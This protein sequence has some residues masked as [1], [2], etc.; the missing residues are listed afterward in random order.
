MCRTPREGSVWKGGVSTNPIYSSAHPVSKKERIQV[1]FQQ[2]SARINDDFSAGEQVNCAR[3]CQQ[4]WA[5]RT[6]SCV[7]GK[8][9]LSYRS[10]DEHPFSCWKLKLCFCFLNEQLGT[11]W[12]NGLCTVKTVWGRWCTGSWEAVKP[13]VHLH[14][15]CLCGFPQAPHLPCRNTGNTGQ[16]TSAVLQ[17]RRGLWNTPSWGANPRGLPQQERHRVWTN[18]VPLVLTPKSPPLLGDPHNY[19][20]LSR[21]CMTP[22]PRVLPHLTVPLPSQS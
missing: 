5:Q 1:S 17:Q 15:R 22:S 12:N 10:V 3:S 13:P 9:A 21:A 2:G 7:C 8:E 14:L 18:P 6:D 4:R 19:L 16:L 20:C 11:H